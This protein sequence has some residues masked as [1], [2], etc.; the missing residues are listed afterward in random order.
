MPVATGLH[1]SPSFA[2]EAVRA[3]GACWVYTPETTGIAEDDLLGQL[4]AP[5]QSDGIGGD[6]ATA[7]VAWSPDADGAELRLETSGGT[8]RGS[9]R[10]ISLELADGPVLD[11][12]T[13]RE[14]TAHAVLRLIAPG[15]DVAAELTPEELSERMRIASTEFAVEAGEQAD[16]LVFTA[17]DVIDLV[18][19]GEYRVVLQSVHFVVTEETVPGSVTTLHWA[20]NAQQGTEPTASAAPAPGGTEVVP[21]LNPAASPEPFVG[22]MSEFAVQ[23]TSLLLLDD[24]R[25]QV[26][27]AA[28]RAGD[29]LV[30][31]ASGMETS[32]S[33]N[34]GFGPAGGP[35][36]LD[37]MVVTS[38]EEGV[39]ERFEVAVP[40]GAVVG[41]GEVT[42]VKIGTPEVP[43]APAGVPLSLRIL[44]APVLTATETVGD[45]RLDVVVAGVGFDP[46]TQV[47]VRGRA[48]EAAASD[49]AVEV[50]T[51][52]DGAFTTD[53]VLTDLDATALRARQT[54]EAS[55]GELTA[56]VELANAVPGPSGSKPP[57]TPPAEVPTPITPPVAVP[58]SVPAPSVPA[59]VVPAPIAPIAPT[60]P[61]LNIPLPETAPIVEV[62]APEVPDA[63]AV[64]ELKLTEPTL[65]GSVSMG[66]LFGGSSERRV[67]FEVEN[68][69]GAAAD[70]PDVLLGIGRTADATPSTVATSL[71]TIEPGAR[72]A[73]G[74]NLALPMASFGTY[75][76]VGQVGDETATSFSVR[77]DTYPW[78]LFA[79]NVAGVG[80]LVWGV[81]RRR[82]KAAPIPAGPE[83]AEAGASVVDLD[84]LDKWWKE[85][86]VVHAAPEVLEDNDSVVDLDA[87]DR[88][89][90]RNKGNVS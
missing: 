77:W 50:W 41:Q 65:E 5:V 23:N 30:L 71:G 25:G 14:G 59:P 13:R 15:E 45:E 40:Q 60:A 66:E 33:F 39:V 57:V 27:T 44:G 68:V 47:R 17:E 43:S 84:A 1:A 4:T 75:Q 19:E 31:S 55:F 9:E 87:A 81:S 51:D 11:A 38:D 26:G 2:A 53:Y 10:S 73:V 52:V 85:G 61:P 64:A 58:P 88:W 76:V 8:A 7:P 56:R 6:V 72:V 3:M 20:C 74:I 67:V 82:T 22:V 70:D 86:K 16:G 63:I 62:P 42:L 35:Y 46:L 80:L 79:A 18:D 49:K 89:W 12:T 90:A 28:A 48:G 24:V 78:G 34:V 36:V 83:T 32:S 54:R 69:G 21:A 29:V 37:N